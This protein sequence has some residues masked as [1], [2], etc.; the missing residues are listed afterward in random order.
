LRLRLEAL[1]PPS[2]EALARGLGGLRDQ[3]RARF[4]DGTQRRRAL[5][6]ALA[7]GGPLDPLD[8][9]SAARLEA[10]AAGTAG[11]TGGAVEIV[12]RSPDPDDL[13]LRE[14]RLLGSADCVAHE[15]G[16]PEAVLLRARADAVRVA[17]AQGAAAPARSGLVVAVRAPG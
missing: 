16:V 13:T 10:W 4:P 8:P 2:L 3:L 9:A 15:P 5:D 17:L 12:L 7:V 1:L 6:A 14:A 11:D